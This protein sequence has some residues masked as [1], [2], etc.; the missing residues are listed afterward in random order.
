MNSVALRRVAL[1]TASISVGGIMA[2]ILLCSVFKSTA[3]YCSA[4]NPESIQTTAAVEGIAISCTPLVVENLAYYDGAFFEDGSGTE[5]FGVASVVLRNNSDMT[6]PYA[7]VIVYTNNCRYEFEATMLPPH[8]KVLIPDRYGTFLTESSITKCF[9]WITVS[10]LP[11]AND[12][13]VVESECI[14]IN[15]PSDQP[16]KNIIVYYR[17]YLPENNIF[18]GGRA[19]SIEIPAIAAGETIMLTPD[20]YAPGYSKVVWYTAE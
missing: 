15:N 8:A 19:F 16:V 13:C 1:S 11:S 10:Y 18:L 3:L 7:S 5:K 9:G 17:T 14:Q 6:I 20:H 2:A 4:K 12:L